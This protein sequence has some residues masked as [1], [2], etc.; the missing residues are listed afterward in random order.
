MCNTDNGAILSSSSQWQDAVD[1]YRHVIK[2]WEKHSND[3]INV[4]R[5]PRIH[6][7]ENLADLLDADHCS[8]N[9]DKSPDHPSVNT[10]QCSTNTDQCSASTDKCSS[11]TDLCSNSTDQCSTST[12]Q[13]SSSTDQC[14]V[15]ADQSSSSTDQCSTSTDQSSINRQALRDEDLRSEVC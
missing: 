7:L 8:I 2:I 5:L 11:S 15:S 6:T 4:D 13:S 10:D 14:S 3:A 1:M 12:G 9:D